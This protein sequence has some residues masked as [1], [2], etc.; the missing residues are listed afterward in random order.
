MPQERVP[1]VGF[2]VEWAAP[3]QATIDTSSVNMDA[4]ATRLRDVASAV[5]MHALRSKGG[6]ATV[7][8]TVRRK[9][10]EPW[11]VGSEYSY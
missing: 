11:Q 1:H 10:K 8:I 2:T 6:T 9:A 7:T 4:A 5:V 3:M